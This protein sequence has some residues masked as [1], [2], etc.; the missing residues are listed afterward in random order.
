MED[1]SILSGHRTTVFNRLGELEVDDQILIETSAG[2]FTYQI[3]E[4]RIVDRSDQTVIM[5]T[6]SAVLTLTTCY[7]FDSIIRTTKAFIVKADLV[8][9]SLAK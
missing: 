8:E 9:S 4:F 2:I 5:P 7:P 3:Q 6:P 1:N